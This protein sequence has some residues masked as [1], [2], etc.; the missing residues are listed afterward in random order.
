[1]RFH[2]TPGGNGAG[3]SGAAEV[4]T[5]VVM[6]SLIPS[7]LLPAYTLLWR[8]S[9]MY[10]PVLVGGLILIRYIR[11]STGS[12]VVEIPDDAENPSA[13]GEPT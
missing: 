1:M 10:F 5:A 11:Q 4:G 2:I 3:G 12:N 9:I 8:T 6:Q 13:R 7:T